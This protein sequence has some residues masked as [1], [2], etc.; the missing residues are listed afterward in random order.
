[1]RSF[2]SH[3]VV[4]TLLSVVLNTYVVASPLCVTYTGSAPTNVKSEKGVI[5]KARATFAIS[6]LDLVITLS[7]VGTND[8]ATF[9][10]T[11]TGIFFNIAG[12]PSLTPGSAKVARGSSVVGDRPL[13]PGFDGDVSGQWAYRG[14]LPTG[15][16]SKD[17]PGKY[18]L[19]CMAD[20]FFHK[21]NL[22]SDIKIPGTY[23]L[24]HDEFGITT[25]NDL[26]AS[27]IDD[28]SIQNEIVLVLDGL[29]VNFSLDQISDVTFEYGT[30]IK[31]GVN[32]AGEMVAEIPEPSPVAL[33]A[34]GLLGT[35]AL[36]RTRAR[37]R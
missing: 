24:H 14:D 29:P 2:A 32:I 18:G 35:L 7:N 11:L 25:L 17:A 21:T 31:R 34:V 19:S 23:P 37:P 33:V 20:S 13:P 5:L 28:Y 26:P 15:S 8:P 3:L 36:T 12:N 22:F 4:L 10:D 30:S 9:A 6:N 16:L 1:M 27:D